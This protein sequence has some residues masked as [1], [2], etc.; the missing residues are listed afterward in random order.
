MEGRASV[1]AQRTYWHLE[2]QQLEGQR[3]LP[4]P[5][6]I[7]TSKLLY[8][9]ERG[10]ELPTPV[11]AWMQRHGAAS[12]LQG[13]FEAFRDPRATTYARYVE[14]QAEQ[15][16]FV[17]QLLV[18]A[19]ETG[20]DAGLSPA[21]LD[22]LEAVLPVLRYP[23]HALHMLA[24]Y[25]AHL[26]PEGRVVVAGAFQAADELRRVQ[27]LA[28]RM[29]QLQERRA[30]FGQA[31]R[32]HWQSHSAWQPLRRVLERLLV[33][34]DFGEALVALELVVK[35]V[36]DE[37]YWV[38]FAALARERGDHLFAQLA[39]SLD[40][41]CRWQC[42]WSD[43]LLRVAL[44]EHPENLAALR[45]WVGRWWPPLQAALPPLLSLW[46]VEPERAL[47]L[48]AR[49]ELKC[50]ARWGALGIES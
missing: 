22:V 25:V 3:R 20:Y 49:V 41:D 36:L 46:A 19:E 44:E 13:R 7:V 17:E 21:W 34:Y 38:E 6:D 27:H 5:Y 33:T 14:L 2:G 47:V 23:S 26:A 45:D 16:S 48:A 29:R 37:L 50:R 18:S 43:A 10:F 40:R 8:Y 24:A 42:D 39:H 1:T 31:A 32:E 9:P 11:G 35:P 12:R 15:E 28:H 30:G 4:Q